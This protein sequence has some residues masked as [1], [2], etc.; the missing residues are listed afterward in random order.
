M[1]KYAPRKISL[2]NPRDVSSLLPPYIII[3]W[4]FRDACTA[5]K[6]IPPLLK[7]FL[8]SLEDFVSFWSLY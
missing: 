6:S 1:K 3:T 5:G 7:G 2:S 8:D 4:F